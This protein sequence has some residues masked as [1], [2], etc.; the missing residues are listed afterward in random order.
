[1]DSF[2][3]RIQEVTNGWLVEAT[4]RRDGM[5][6]VAGDR[7]ALMEMVTQWVESKSLFAS[8]ARR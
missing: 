2:E 8:G 7:E 6:A 1:M 5:M 3:L 4:S